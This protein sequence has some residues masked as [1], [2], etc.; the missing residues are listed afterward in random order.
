MA[1]I[2]QC[3][4]AIVGGGLAGTLI[5]L[6]VKAR[7]PDLDV[8]IVEG[9]VGLGGHHLWSFFGSDVDAEGRMLLKPLV[10]HGWQSYDVVFPHHRRTLPQSYF[11]IRSERLNAH[12]RA[13]LSPQAV[14]T[15]RRVLACSATA[16]VLADGDRIEATGVIDARGAGD[17]S[18][19]HVGWQKFVGVEFALRGHGLE[20]PVVMDASVDQI[21]GYRFVYCLPFTADTM[22]I[23]DTY[24]SDSPE[25]DEPALETRI[26][27][28]AANRGWAPGERLRTERGVLPVV[29]GGDFAAYWRSGGEKL[30]KAGTRAGLFH[31]TTGYSL[32]DAVRLAL[33]VAAS[34]DL[35]GAALCTLT[36]DHAARAWRDRRFY[37]LLDAMLFRAAE[38]AERYRVLER[39]YR[40]PDGLVARFYAARSTTLDKARVLAGRPP[41][42]VSRALVALKGVK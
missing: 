5:A 27:D 2:H 20:R 16:V 34:R 7:Q 14:M 22:L 38:P 26:A 25:L 29:I 37:R 41:V 40:L 1:T 31:P 39:F 12:A 17:L 8:R 35:S 3:D 4:L 24:Y 6:A 11:T 30:A 28:Y 19:L 21:D 42:K 15:G 9:G 32:P 33:A 18:A 23:E 13:V 10:G 36:H